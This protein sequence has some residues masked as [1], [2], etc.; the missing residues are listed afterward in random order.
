MNIIT[1]KTMGEEQYSDGRRLVD[2][3]FVAV[4]VGSSA[5]PTGHQSRYNWAPCHIHLGT[6]ADTV[7]SYQLVEQGTN[8]STKVDTVTGDS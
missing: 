3:R 4:K 8:V 7:S 2:L 5:Y 6:R 1:F